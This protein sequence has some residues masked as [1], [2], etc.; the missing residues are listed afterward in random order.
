MEMDMEREN[1]GSANKD[2]IVS[3]ACN[4]SFNAIRVINKLLKGNS[5]SRRQL[6]KSLD[7]STN[8]QHSF[9]LDIRTYSVVVLNEKLF[10]VGYVQPLDDTQNTTSIY[11]TYKKY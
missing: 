9:K 8:N 5:D 3:R 6:S 2:R 7:P 1:R 10:H 11:C 4:S